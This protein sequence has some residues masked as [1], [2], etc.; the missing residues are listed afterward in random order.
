MTANAPPQK[1]GRAALV[2]VVLVG[3]ALVV[4]AISLFPSQEKGE[5]VRLTYAK[6]RPVVSRVLAQGRVR[7]KRQ[8]DVQ[9]EVSG[10]VTEIFVKT[11][12]QVAPGDALFALDP[13]QAENA[14]AQLR[15]ALR[16]ANATVSRM[17]LA[18]EEAAR[19][20]RRDQR[21]VERGVATAEVARASEAREKMARTDLLQAQANRDRAA[22]EFQRAKDT[23]EKSQVLAP[24]AG[25]VV[26][27]GIEVGQLVAPLASSGFG[28]PGGSAALGTVGGSTL[29]HV[30]IA[31]LSELEARLDVDE[32]DVARVHPG[33]SVQ[34]R[35][36][37]AQGET[38]RGTVTEVGLLGQQSG[39]AVMFPV[40]VSI[41]REV[42]PAIGAAPPESPRPLR[43]A[44]RPGMT[45]SADIEVERLPEAIAVPLAAVLEGDGRQKPDRVFVAV[46]ID[47][48]DDKSGS[49]KERAVT[50]GPTE[51]DVVAILAGVAAG[52]AVVE[53]PFRALR[54][55]EDDAAITVKE[56][57]P[58][59]EDDAK[60]AAKPTGKTGAT[61][62]S[63]DEGPKKD[64]ENEKTS[65]AS[66]ESDDVK[67]ETAP[68]ATDSA[69]KGATVQ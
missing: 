38:L 21:L 54:A 62:R 66:A 29:P 44:L 16:A 10:R 13:E 31:D 30:V 5:E 8:V 40:E 33:Q 7:A 41:E 46:D 2:G 35:A 42:A 65:P 12:Q 14:V 17:Q 49:V 18:I 60:N 57:V 43:R 23:L 20:T 61:E 67:G 51:S 63:V 39:G 28:S 58:L 47:D 25:T 53:G 32:L 24:I 3:A 59:S 26:A 55:L 48:K 68:T 64:A 69:P 50:L 56:I 9:S 37:G 15:V 45:V 36:Q 52:E 22:L 1:E 6:A 19:G 4:G 27:V 11:G 34:I